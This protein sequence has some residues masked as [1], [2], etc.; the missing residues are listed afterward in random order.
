MTSLRDHPLLTDENMHPAVVQYLRSEGM[1]VLDVKESG[2]IGTDDLKL[3]RLATAQG[4]VIVT[5][6]R[7]FG[8]LAVA[9]LEPIVGSSTSA[10]DASTR[11]SQSSQRVRP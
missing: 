10:R 2:L 7:D 4:R 11:R 6:D 8:A 3:V 9:T 5:H 1:N